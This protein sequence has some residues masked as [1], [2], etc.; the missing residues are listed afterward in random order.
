ME[1][2]RGDL[3]IDIDPAVPNIAR[4]YDCLLGGKDNFEVD[5]EHAAELLKRLPQAERLARENRHFLMRAVRFLAEEAGVAQFIDIGAGLPTADNT[6]QVAQRTNPDARV[7]Y[8]DNDPHV[9]AHGRALLAGQGATA[10]VQADMRDPEAI[11]SHAG[12]RQLI[13]FTRPVAV[14]LVS[15]LHLVA[16]DE[17]AELTGYWRR[18]LPRGSHLVISHAEDRPALRRAAELYQE[19]L[20]TGT[21]RTRDEIVALFEGFELV[22]PGVVGLPV[23]RPETSLLP[24]GAE[25]SPMLCGV[26]RCAHA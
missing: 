9:L 22:P 11:F 4:V 26:G 23:W 7:V 15:V 10:V 5:R 8:A 19:R 13:D 12:T 16:G 3:A 6:H 25:D 2:A 24:E 20:G 17:A 21:L 18:T 1:A 14:L